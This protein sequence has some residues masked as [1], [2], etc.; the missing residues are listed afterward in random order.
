MNTQL[1]LECEVDELFQWVSEPCT[2]G[3][4][5]GEE[6]CPYCDGANKLFHHIVKLELDA[7]RYRHLRN[8]RNTKGPDLVAKYAG[9]DLDAAID[10]DMIIGINDAKTE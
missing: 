10:T 2:C 7:R 8:G 3:T 6:Y 4:T 1:E 5:Y 9:A